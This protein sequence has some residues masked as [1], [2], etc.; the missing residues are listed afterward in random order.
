MQGVFYTNR[1][2]E[3]GEYQ[4]AIEDND[5]QANVAWWD[6]GTGVV[7]HNAAWAR[8]FSVTWDFHRRSAATTAAALGSPLSHPHRY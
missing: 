7:Y 3:P 4:R 1:P 6:Q 2:Q 5:P 8:E